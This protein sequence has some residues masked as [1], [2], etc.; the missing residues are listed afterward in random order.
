MPQK[1][2]AEK[3]A[4]DTRRKNRRKF[5]AEEEIRI[6][7]EG[8]RGEESIASLCRR[9]CSQPPRRLQL[10]HELVCSRDSI[11]VNGISSGAAYLGHL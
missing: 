9:G 6:V 10:S 4:R 7:L 8:L 5:S 3:A 2:S 11:A 1:D